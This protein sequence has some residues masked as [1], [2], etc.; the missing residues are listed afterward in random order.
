MQIQAKY[1]KI[2]N[3]ILLTN[4]G[5]IN[6]TIL[7]KSIAAACICL[8]TLSAFASDF[9]GDWTE[10]FNLKKGHFA[11]HTPKYVALDNMFKSGKGIHLDGVNINGTV[12]KNLNIETDSTRQE[13][14]AALKRSNLYN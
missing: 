12:I 4:V 8:F 11:V 14:V 3:S 1:D 6:M 2:I 5:A 13:F 9:K 7:R 10:K